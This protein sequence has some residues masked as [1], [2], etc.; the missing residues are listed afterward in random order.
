MYLGH[1]AAF[2]L[3]RKVLGWKWSLW[4]FSGHPG[5]GC[6][7]QDGGL[8]YPAQCQP[9]GTTFEAVI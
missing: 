1:C 5:M 9:K 7:H 6:Q 2:R 4:D 8:I 3:I